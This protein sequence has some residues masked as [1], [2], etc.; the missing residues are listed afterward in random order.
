MD[1]A[2]ASEYV[3]A[4]LHEIEEAL[5]VLDRSETPFAYTEQREA[6]VRHAARLLGVLATYD[7]AELRLN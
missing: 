3:A 1:G 5:E 7:Q 6:L 2:W 4:K